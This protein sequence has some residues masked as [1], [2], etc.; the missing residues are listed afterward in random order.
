[1]WHHRTSLVLS[2]S[3]LSACV[4]LVLGACVPFGAPAVQSTSK[5]KLSVVGFNFAESTLLVYLYAK[6][7]AAKGYVVETKPNLGTRETLQPALVSGQADM[8][9]GYAATDLEFVNKGAGEASADIQPTLAK[10]RERYKPLGVDVLDAAPAVDKTVFAVT[11][12][13]AATYHIAKLS[14]LAPIAGQLVLG[15]PPQCPQRPFC[16][17]GLERV[18]GIKFKDFKALDPGGPLTKEALDAGQID[19]ALLLSSDGAIPAKGYVVLDDDRHLELADNVVPMIRTAVNNPEI[20]QILNAV[21][22]KLTTEDLAGL[23]KRA[24][25]DHEEPEALA[26]EWLRSKGL[27]P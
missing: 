18:Y 12:D 27:L 22:A 21:S 5:S 11:K 13:T 24:S 10:L 9:L 2:A 14:D 20:T 6:P 3:A 16:M 15:A 7:L 17:P 8:Y 25:I 23:N 19:V 1:M 26:T 4:A